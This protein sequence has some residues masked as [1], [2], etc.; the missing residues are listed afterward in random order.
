MLKNLDLAGIVNSLLSS[1]DVNGKSLG[2]KLSGIDLTVLAG[3]GSLQNYTSVRT[4][5]G[6]RMNAKRVVA[7]K[8]AV[9]LSVLRYIVQNLK[10]N[11]NAINSLLAGLEISDDVLEIINTV[12]DAL[13][14][15]DV[16]AVIEL[17]ADILFNINSGEIVLEPDKPAEADDAFIPFIPGNFYWVYWVIFAV[18]VAAIGVGLFFILKKKKNEEEYTDVK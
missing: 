2:I 3:R 17:L 8:P 13:A 10:T 1:V 6:V 5:N 12:L 7:D 18:A 9:L 16:D 11:L 15:E 4:Y 14:T